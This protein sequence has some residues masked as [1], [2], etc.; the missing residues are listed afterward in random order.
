MKK[1]L[2]AVLAVMLLCALPTFAFASV[3]N[4]GVCIQHVDFGGNAVGYG[5][6]NDKWPKDPWDI[7][8][9]GTYSG[10]IKNLSADYDIYTKYYFTC[11]SSG[12]LKVTGTLTATYPK[13]TSMNCV[14]TLYNAIDK[15]YVDSYDCGTGAYNSKSVSHT[16]KNLVPSTPYVVMFSNKSTASFENALSGPITV[17]Y[18]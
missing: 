5:L 10:E 9:K 4:D 3:E 7:A 18:P 8:T 11:N 2:S 14:I 16:F 6:R 15:S 17:G 1:L 13:T 12:Q